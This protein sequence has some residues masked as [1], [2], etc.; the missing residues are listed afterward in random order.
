MMH[1]NVK[2]LLLDVGQFEE[3]S[4]LLSRNFQESSNMI[5]QEKGNFTLK[6]RSVFVAM[7][8]LN[9]FL[10]LGTSWYPKLHLTAKSEDTLRNAVTWKS[11]RFSNAGSQ[12]HK[13][14]W[15]MVRLARGT[16]SIPTLVE[17]S[18]WHRHSGKL[19]IP[20]WEYLTLEGE[21]YFSFTNS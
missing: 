3:I 1:Y 19:S 6:S 12:F 7:P 13:K 18:S 17:I 20:T 11:Q 21:V 8:L 14:S 4:S 16:F 10:Y 9:S 2:C 15:V 5:C